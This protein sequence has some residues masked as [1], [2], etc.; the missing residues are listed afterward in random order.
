MQSRPGLGYAECW[1]SAQS[2]PAIML[3]G[4]GSQL[5]SK[6]QVNNNVLDLQESGS[7]SAGAKQAWLGHPLASWAAA[8]VFKHPARGNSQGSPAVSLQC[9]NATHSIQGRKY[10]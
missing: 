1:G 2:R 8:R 3:L 6:F 7:K 4:S 5:N 10:N 9:L